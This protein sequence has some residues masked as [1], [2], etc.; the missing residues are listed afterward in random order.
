[1]LERTETGREWVARL[2]RRLLKQADEN[3]ILVLTSSVEKEPLASW[4]KKEG[5]KGE[6]EDINS[7]EPAKDY[8]III[9]DGLE[10]PYSDTAETIYKQIL[11]KT[12]FVI[13]ILPESAPDILDRYKG[14]QL[15]WQSEQGTFYAGVDEDKQNAKVLK[16]AYMPKYGVYG[17]YGDD[18]ELIDAYLQSLIGANQIVLCGNNST[19][20]TFDRI[21]AFKSEHPEISLKH[22][23]LFIQPPRYDDAKNIC[24][25]FMPEDMDVNICLELNQTLSQDWRSLLDEKWDP[26]VMRYIHSVGVYKGS[27]L[28]TEKKGF[29]IHKNGGFIW[30]LPV[31]EYLE[32]KGAEKNA[33]LAGIPVYQRSQRLEK[34]E[35]RK[36]LILLAL[37]EKPKLPQLWFYLAQ[38]QVQEEK[39]LDALSSLDKGESLGLYKTAQVVELRYKLFKKIGITPLALTQLDQLFFLLPGRREVYYEKAR[40]LYELGRYQEAYKMM[41]AGMLFDERK[42]DEYSNSE[43]WGEKGEAFLEELRE[44]CTQP[45]E[46]AEPF[47]GK[48]G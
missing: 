23:A 27:T 14:L 7:W 42:E 5:L 38:I 31:Y 13:L 30:R 16:D 22:L 15:K 12:S 28:E 48:E 29:Q 18:E 3:G 17:V 33:E 2:A 10:D 32:Y 6:L 37:K 36:A 35:I 9:V 26:A 46:K 25:S 21:E 41:T 45:K 19:D 1:M 43:C 4:L 47:P 8:D 44:K 34:T 24:L 11:E 39:Y 20:G 40:Y